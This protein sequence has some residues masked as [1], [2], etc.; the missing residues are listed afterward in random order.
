M[1]S[2]TVRVVDI[3]RREYC[4]VNNPRA[5]EQNR[6]DDCWLA[7]PSLTIFATIMLYTMKQKRN[8]NDVTSEKKMPYI[9]IFIPAPT[10]VYIV[11][12]FL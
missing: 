11:H 5:K 1:Q 4:I 2:L 6:A 7:T 10:A 3:S 9:K 12:T 8:E